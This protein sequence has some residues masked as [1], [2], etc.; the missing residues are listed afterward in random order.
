[1]PL[2]QWGAGKADIEAGRATLARVETDARAR[3]AEMAENARFAA[4]R[5]V[6]SQ[7]GLEIAAKADSVSARRYAVTKVQYDR[8]TATLTELLTAQN[9][10]DAARAASAQALRAYW[11][12]YYRLRQLT[13][14]DFVANAPIE[15]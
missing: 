11:T 3:R 6:Q 15:N 12:T 14:Y 2:L 7:S 4:F 13:L 8:G 1:M 10:K 5:F 9:D